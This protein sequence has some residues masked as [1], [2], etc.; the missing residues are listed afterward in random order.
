[1]PQLTICPD[2]TP[3]W[4]AAAFAAGGIAAWEWDCRQDTLMVDRAF[5]AALFDVAT[6]PDSDVIDVRIRELTGLI[7]DAACRQESF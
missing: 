6:D 1:M 7:H 4:R 2:V 3:E 5:I